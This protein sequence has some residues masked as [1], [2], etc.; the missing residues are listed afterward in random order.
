MITPQYVALMARYYRWMNDKLFAAS[1]LL[2]DEQHKSDRRAFFKSIHLTLNH[3]MRGDYTWLGRFTKATPLERAYQKVAFGTELYPDWQALKSE[4]L[5]LDAD[6]C[7]WAERIDV[8]WLVCVFF[9]LCG[10]SF[11]P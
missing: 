8:A 11:S 2:T 3:L 5:N 7:A 9:C 10:L 4:R 6:I 1:E